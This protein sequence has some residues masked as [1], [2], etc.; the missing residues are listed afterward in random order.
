M[1]SIHLHVAIA[2]RSQLS[3]YSV[4]FCSFDRRL[5]Q[6]AKTYGFRV[7]DEEAAKRGEPLKA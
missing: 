6:A 1:D 3:E 2:F 5:I 4:M 7:L